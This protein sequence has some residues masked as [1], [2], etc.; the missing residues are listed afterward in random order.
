MLAGPLDMCNGW[1]DLNNSLERLKVFEELPGTVAAELAKLVVV[2]SG[3]HIL[4]DAPEEYLKKEDLFEFIRLM[5]PEFDSYRVLKGEIGEYISVARKSGEDWF[6]GSLTNRS[7]RDISIN[8]DFLDEGY[9]YSAV[10]FGD[11]AETH[12]LNNKE[13]YT[14]S[15][16]VEVTGSDTLDIRLAEGGGNA[17]IIKKLNNEKKEQGSQRP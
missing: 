11:S 5:P 12:F 4:P 17:I 10:V 14:I 1:F 7:A 13:S 6:I 3:W 2:Y 8:L 16:P 15:E 9:V